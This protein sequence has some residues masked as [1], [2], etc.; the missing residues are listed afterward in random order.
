MA[1]VNLMLGLRCAEPCLC[2]CRFSQ[3]FFTLRSFCLCVRCLCRRNCS[4]LLRFAGIPK[5]YARDNQKDQRGHHRS[6]HDDLTEATAPRRFFIFRSAAGSEIGA[7]VSVEEIR[8]GCAGVLTL[9]L[10]QAA[11]TM[12]EPWRGLCVG[13]PF[14]GG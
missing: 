4:L 2:L 5:S 8:E 9:G 3:T 14:H 10:L 11:G 7:F 13:V 6:I 12:G 1:R